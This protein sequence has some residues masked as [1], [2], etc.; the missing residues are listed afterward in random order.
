[1]T[2]LPDTDEVVAVSGE[3]GLTVSGP[4][5]GEALGRVAPSA[6]RNLKV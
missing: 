3:Q 4:G 2:N 1:M 5:Q 6:A